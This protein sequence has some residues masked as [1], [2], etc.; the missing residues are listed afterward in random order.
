MLLR[1]LPLGDLSSRALVVH[2]L[3]IR[4]VDVVVNGVATKLGVL[5]ESHSGAGANTKAGRLVIAAKVVERG[6]ILG[7]LPA[8][9]TILLLLEPEDR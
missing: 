8:E 4:S 1:E 5:E 2:L 9:A 6:T 7:E 3:Q